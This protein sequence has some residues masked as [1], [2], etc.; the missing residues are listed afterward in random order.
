MWHC[1]NN[2]YDIIFPS[3]TMLNIDEVVEQG[4]T[5]RLLF[6]GQ[7]V[8]SQSFTFPAANQQACEDIR[9]SILVTTFFLWSD[10]ILAVCC[11]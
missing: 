10:R 5:R 6:E 2:Y 1:Y 4:G 7:E 11:M 8:Y 3:E 9:V